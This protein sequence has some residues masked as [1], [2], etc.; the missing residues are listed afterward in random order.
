MRSGRALASTDSGEP[1]LKFLTDGQ[2]RYF[3]DLHRFCSPLGTAVFA[4]GKDY[5]APRVR[6]L[7]GLLRERFG[8]IAGFSGGEVLE[9]HLDLAETV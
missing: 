9:A 8:G 4:Q 3:F 7:S 2:E 1:T 6:I 5:N